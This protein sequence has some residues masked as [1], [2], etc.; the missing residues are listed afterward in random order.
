MGMIPCKQCRAE[1]LPETAEMTGGL[2]MPCYRLRPPPERHLIAELCHSTYCPQCGQG[3]EWWQCPSEC[4]PF[5]LARFLCARC[6]TVT[7]ASAAGVSGLGLLLL[8]FAYFAYSLEAA[9]SLQVPLLVVASLVTL[10]GL[11]RIRQQVRALTRSRVTR[12]S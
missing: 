8:I 10:S 7:K 9:A 4:R 2:C 6:D 11:L 3:Y 12:E 5:R 1:I